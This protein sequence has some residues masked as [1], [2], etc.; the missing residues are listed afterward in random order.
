[1]AKAFIVAHGRVQGVGYRSV[2]AYVAKK[3]GVS[4]S[5]RNADDG[6]VQIVAC[7]DK[8]SI[9]RF[10]REISISIKNG[11]DVMN[12]EVHY[13]GEPGYPKTTREYVGF[14]IER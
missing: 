9:S 4:G 5:V 10:I 1:M 14:S 3:L 12:V 11:P 13:E 7:A 6:S 8:D 2:V